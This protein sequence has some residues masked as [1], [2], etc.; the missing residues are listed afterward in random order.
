M[1]ATDRINS[2]KSTLSG[3]ADIEYNSISSSRT[4]AMEASNEKHHRLPS[5][6]KAVLIVF[7]IHLAI[8]IFIRIGLPAM[9]S[10]AMRRAIDEFLGKRQPRRYQVPNNINEF[11]T[12]KP[13]FVY[14]DT[15][16]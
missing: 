13:V 8:W 16:S 14:K 15:A 11:L 5:L 1:A 12:R 2:N 9:T 4:A 6:V 3:E 10:P 7:L